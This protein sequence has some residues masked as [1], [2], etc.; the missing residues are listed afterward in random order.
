M[1]Q[2]INGAALVSTDYVNFPHTLPVLICHGEGDKVTDHD[3]SQELAEKLKQQGV[4]DVEF[5]S[6]EGYY[7]RL[8]F[9]FQSRSLYHGDSS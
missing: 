5:K 6:Y 3:A 2:L 4:K 9:L 8:F 1:L 7:V